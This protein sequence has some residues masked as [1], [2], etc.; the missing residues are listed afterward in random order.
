MEHQKRGQRDSRAGCG[1]NA[2]KACLLDGIHCTHEPV[3][4]A[5]W[6]RSTLCGDCQHFNKNGGGAYEAPP[7]LRN[8]W[9]LTESFSSMI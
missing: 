6:T 1:R 9:K 7:L 5:N 8:F 4:G 3:A 2:V